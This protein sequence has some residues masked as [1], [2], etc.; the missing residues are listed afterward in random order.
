MQTALLQLNGRE[1]APVPPGSVQLTWL[2]PAYNSP[3]GD[4]LLP[5]RTRHAVQEAVRAEA[6]AAEQEERGW[7]VVVLPIKRA[8]CQMNYAAGDVIVLSTGLYEPKPAVCNSAGSSAARG[9]FWQWELEADEFAAAVMLRA[10]VL[11]GALGEALRAGGSSRVQLMRAASASLKRAAAALDAANDRQGEGRSEAQRLR[12]ALKA[13]SADQ[14]VRLAA[15]WGAMRDRQQ[16]A[17]AV[18][19][20]ADSGGTVMVRAGYLFV[21]GEDL[22]TLPVNEAV[23]MLQALA[24]T[25][26]PFEARLARLR[27]L[28]G[29]PDMLLRSAAPMPAPGT[30]GGSG[31]SPAEHVAEL[32]AAAQAAE[33]RQRLRGMLRETACYAAHA[34]LGVFILGSVASERGGKKHHAS[35]AKRR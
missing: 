7:N 35:K 29:R 13:R 3:A 17:A 2:E 22:A 8:V 27:Q 20:A 25:H 19:R 9:T 24:D 14:L 31:L 28:A 10:K 4:A 34:A 26:P 12:S 30:W 33:R 32:V 15:R 11:P 16:A 5:E 23:A 18:A 6:A 21:R 1:L